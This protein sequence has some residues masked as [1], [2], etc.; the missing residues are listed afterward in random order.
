MTPTGIMAH[1]HLP[2]FIAPSLPS[3]RCFS[4]IVSLCNPCCI[5]PLRPG[6][7]SPSYHVDTSSGIGHLRHV[8]I[9]L[10]MDSQPPTQMTSG[11]SL[12]FVL[13]PVRPR[14]ALVTARHPHVGLEDLLQWLGLEE[15][16][17]GAALG[18]EA[19]SPSFTLSTEGNEWTRYPF[20]APRQSPRFRKRHEAS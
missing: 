12:A 2:S 8:H 6:P 4:S 16:W 5:L 18:E 15:Q 19:C 1:Y 11:S 17:V 9:H 3:F 14:Y 20:T 10:P 7:Y 13:S